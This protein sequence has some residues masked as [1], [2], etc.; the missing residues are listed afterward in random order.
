MTPTYSIT[1]ILDFLHLLD[2]DELTILGELI[3]EEIE[4][5]TIQE[6]SIIH[7]NFFRQVQRVAKK[8]ADRVM[9]QIWVLK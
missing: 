2:L 8:E 3:T 4:R 7:A 5:Y 1:E 6:L 9:E